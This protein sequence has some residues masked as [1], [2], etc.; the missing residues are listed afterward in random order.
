MAVPV[1]NLNADIEVLEESDDSLGFNS[2]MD[3]EFPRSLSPTIVVSKP[4][5]PRWGEFDFKTYGYDPES[6]YHYETEDYFSSN[7]DDEYLLEPFLKM[8]KH[9][10]KRRDHHRALKMNI[11][12]R[13]LTGRPHSPEEIEKAQ[14]LLF[15]VQ[16]M[17][18][19]F[20]KKQHYKVERDSSPDSEPDW[21]G[22]DRDLDWYNR[23]DA[24][25][26]DS[27]YRRI[28]KY[29]QKETLLWLDNFE[30]A[31]MWC[32]KR[33]PNISV[34][35][36]IPPVWPHHHLSLR[37]E[38][39][40]DPCMGYRY[41]CDGDIVVNA[42]G[43]PC[44]TQDD[45]RPGYHPNQYDYSRPGNFTDYLNAKGMLE[46][47]IRYP[48][49]QRKTDIMYQMSLEDVHNN[50]E[51]ETT[52]SE[53]FDR[54]YHSEHESDISPQVASVH[55]DMDFEE[56]FEYG[57]G[58]F[59]TNYHPDRAHTDMVKLDR[60]ELHYTM[61]RHF[62]CKRC[63]FILYQDVNDKGGSSKPKCRPRKYWCFKCHQ[64]TEPL[65]VLT[66]CERQINNVPCRDCFS[67]TVSGVPGFQFT[68]YTDT[69]MW[70]LQTTIVRNLYED[71][72]EWNHHFSHE[73]W[74]HF[75]AQMY[76]FVKHY[77]YHRHRTIIVAR[78]LFDF[79]EKKAIEAIRREYRLEAQ[80]YLCCLY[81]SK[82]VIVNASQKKVTFPWWFLHFE[83]NTHDRLCDICTWTRIWDRF[84]V[85]HYD[86]LVKYYKQ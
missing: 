40:E 72:W 81:F 41:D 5:K 12:V 48:H 2:I 23:E 71:V 67:L 65:I 35:K 57:L 53:D 10:K 58:I 74:K 9:L 77:H 80:H 73:N 64:P 24:K 34:D 28:I 26:L 7:E 63:N 18:D 69:M 76:D 62:Y 86:H 70:N 14:M 15:D 44:Y 36:L 29:H 52:S 27:R 83:N 42:F 51:P 66:Q 1:V 60:E 85:E 47:I 11:A 56:R 79:L 21:K 37:K 3:M 25:I 4:K 46:D 59:T 54:N 61:H 31:V 49:E 75:R 17:S 78:K 30:K 82:M 68:L 13:P 6:P 38:Q 20:E 55:T 43:V 32:Q 8:K 45:D 33:N 16:N 50:S 84:S 39:D 22:G 19:Y